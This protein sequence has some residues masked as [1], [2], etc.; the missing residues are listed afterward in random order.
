MALYGWQYIIKS[1]MIMKNVVPVI[2][3]KVIGFVQ[4]LLS[5]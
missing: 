3:F 4:Q 1:I 2:K 5:H